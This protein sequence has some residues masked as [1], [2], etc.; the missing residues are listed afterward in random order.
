MLLLQLV[1]SEK[2][3]DFQRSSL[4]RTFTIFNSLQ[5][6][7]D[8]FDLGL[9]A[10]AGGGAGAGTTA[11]FLLFAAPLPLCPVLL[12]GLKD[13]S[14][15]KDLVVMVMFILRRLLKVILLLPP[16]SFLY[17]WRC[18]HKTHFHR[19]LWQLQRPRRNNGRLENRL[20]I[21]DMFLLNV[22]HQKFLVTLEKLLTT[23]ATLN[24]SRI[25]LIRSASRRQQLI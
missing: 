25:D 21:L 5:A 8:L 17:G 23:K 12:V 22:K 20:Q 6:F 3:L 10:N 4:L 9:A 13:L 14:V 18:Q 24:V 15:L 7:L 2:F 11:G 1:I 19:L 16:D